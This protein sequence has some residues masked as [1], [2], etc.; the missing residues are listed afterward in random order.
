[1]PLPSPVCMEAEVTATATATGGEVVAEEEKG[2][3]LIPLLSF[4]QLTCK[5]NRCGAENP[6]LEMVQRPSKDLDLHLRMSVA[7]FLKA[8]SRIL[9]LSQTHT[10]A[11]ISYHFPCPRTSLQLLFKGWRSASEGRYEKRAELV[12]TC[13]E[14]T[15]AMH[16]DRERPLPS[17]ARMQ[18][19]KGGKGRWGEETVEEWKIVEE[20]LIPLPKVSSF[21]SRYSLSPSATPKSGIVVGEHCRGT[22]HPRYALTEVR[23]DEER[24]E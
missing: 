6:H 15:E 5:G 8:S 9:S 20:L 4:L 19:V 17:S 1:M 2:K 16:E 13:V 7:W 22:T 18:E 12:G 23:R 14:E 11:S 3:S 24:E 10:A 21:S